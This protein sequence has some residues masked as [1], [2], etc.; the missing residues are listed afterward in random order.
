MRFH[1]LTDSIRRPAYFYASLF[2]ILSSCVSVNIGPK[3][4]ERSKGVR[5][6]EPPPPYQSLRE[7]QADGAWL[8]SRNGN[9]ISYFSIC[10]DPTDPPLEALSR[11][12]FN[13]LRELKELKRT[14]TVYNGREAL[15]QEVEGKM[16]G[17][18]TRIH[19]VIF[20]KNS[21][22]Y[23]LSL[24]G[25]VR[26]FEEDRAVFEKFLREFHAP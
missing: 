26:A 21:C 4:G 2:F 18:L 14:V 5:Y 3:D 6:A 15:N 16:D 10:N 1:S 9:S 20:K 19:A 24:I 12:L 8:N 22:T 23:T 13:E 7:S 25:V 17:I 11:D